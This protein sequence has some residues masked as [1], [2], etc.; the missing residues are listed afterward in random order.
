MTQTQRNPYIQQVE[1]APNQVYIKR[2]GVWNHV[3]TLVEDHPDW[4]YYFWEILREASL[5]YQGCY[6]TTLYAREAGTW[7]D[8]QVTKPN[9]FWRLSIPP[10]YSSIAEAVA[11]YEQATTELSAMSRWN[12]EEGLE[13]W[14]IRQ[15]FTPSVVS[16]KLLML[17]EEHARFER[18]AQFEARRL[19]EMALEAL[20][21]HLAAV[22]ER[23]DEH[24][25]WLQK[26]NTQSQE[27]REEIGA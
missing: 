21:R 25:R 8:E 4:S 12:K 22:E 19:E 6:V 18:L 17:P 26:K 16:L 13:A 9:P 23:F 2:P 3:H 1:L 27:A 7:V 24:Q 20:Y 10:R 14:C 15:S 5:Y 11:V